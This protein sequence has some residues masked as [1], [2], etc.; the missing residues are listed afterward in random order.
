[1]P[2]AV[3][4]VLVGENAGQVLKDVDVTFP[5]PAV[6]VESPTKRVEITRCEVLPGKVVVIGQVVKNI[7]FKTRK[8]A[9]CP[10][11]AGQ[12]RVVCGDL[13]HCTVTIPFKLMIEVPGAME[14]D[15][16]EVTEACIAG[17]IDTLIDE[18]NDGLFERLAET[19]N[20]L[21]RVRVTRN[22][23]VNV[24]G[25]RRIPRN[26]FIPFPR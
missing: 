16:C 2:D 26:N 20:I 3:L 10:T 7:P 23:V 9:G 13:R 1:M 19:L 14:G 11:V 12:P 18:N 6:E 5:M 17:E 15:T 8:E 24:A 22:E 25:T 21:V 4:P